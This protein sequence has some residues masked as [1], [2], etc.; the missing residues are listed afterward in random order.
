[1]AQP[2]DSEEAARE[3]VGG[4]QRVHFDA[5]HHCS[6]WRL[7]DGVWRTQDAGEPSG[8]AG[9]PI[10]AAIDGAGLVDTAVVVVRYFGG[11]K[12]GVGGL[13]RA[14][15]DAAREALIGARRRIGLRAVRLRVRYPYAHTAQVM[16]VLD[17][18]SAADMEHGFHAASSEPEITASVPA[19][20][21]DRL[22]DELRELT[23]GDVTAEIGDETLL[24]RPA[25]PAP[26][27]LDARR[28]A[29]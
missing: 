12:L 19:D 4:L 28:T 25:P 14:Y 26:G 5:S 10:L 7:R 1:M 9:A 18:V 2:V 24:F 6:A 8:S 17:A 21:V 16:R 23:A 3:L 27:S 13:I 11:T 29:L 22:S 15:G 20:V